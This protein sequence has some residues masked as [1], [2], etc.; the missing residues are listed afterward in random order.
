MDFDP[1]CCPP[2]LSRGVPSG[3]TIIG[4]EVPTVLDRVQTDVAIFNTA[5][6]TQ[7][8]LFTVPAARVTLPG[9]TLRLQLRGDILC[10]TG[11]LPTFTVVMAFGGATWYSDIAQ[12]RTNNPVAIPWRLDV[13][14]ARKT[15]ATMYASAEW[16]GSNTIGAVAIGGGDISQA[17]AT[18]TP[19]NPLD[20]LGDRACDWTI[21]Q[22]ILVRITLGVA[23]A[24]YGITM[25]SGTLVLE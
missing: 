15:A 4:P 7:L 11:G 13:E 12:G 17:G 16:S 19:C 18:L 2:S 20:S 25:R 1:C 5:A 24:A 10:A 8:Y 6:A 9:Q 3:R 21:A 22:D 14:I 23:A